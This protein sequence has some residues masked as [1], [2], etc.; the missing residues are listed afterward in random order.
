LNNNSDFSK[1]EDFL[2][3]SSFNDWVLGTNKNDGVFWEQW[4]LANPDK[5]HLIEGAAEI[6][7]G[8]HFQAIAIEDTQV[9]I[10]LARLH[11]RIDRQ[12]ENTFQLDSQRKSKLNRNRWFWGLAASMALLLAL[13]SWN[14]ISNHQDIVTYATNYGEWEIVEL[15]DGST[16]HLNANS[17]L[18]FSRQWNEGEVR[19]VWLA[20]EAFFEVVKMMD[21]GTEFRVMT[22]DLGV[23]VLGTSF[24]VHARGDQTEVFLEEGKVKLDLGNQITYMVPGETVTYSA[25]KEKIVDRRHTDSVSESPGAWSAGV[26]NLQNAIAFDIFRR[27]E[28]IYG[29]EIRVKDERIYRNEYWVQLPMQELRIVIPIL[30]KSMKVKITQEGNTLFLE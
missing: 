29:V 17:E 10:A 5:Q 28:E 2:D 13:A 26:I 6:V 22:S 19:K 8:I 16:V 20:G 12:R 18:K 4:I 21:V 23:E 3:S 14:W 25:R 15:P 9:E 24:N 27:L 11:E 30:E 1:I 7:K